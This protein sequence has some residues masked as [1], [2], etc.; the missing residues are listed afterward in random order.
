LALSIF[1]TPALISL[2]E[3]FR[4]GH[5]SIIR[6]DALLQE[7]PDVVDLFAIL[8]RRRENSLGRLEPNFA[9]ALTSANSP[10]VGGLVAMATAG[11]SAPIVA[12]AL[13][14]SG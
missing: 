9:P 10:S 3:D 7:P 4:W 14:L 1:R 5:S 6:F 8:L 2:V 13:I 11:L 12:V